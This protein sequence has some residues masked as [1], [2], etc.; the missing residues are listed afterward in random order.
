M[1]KILIYDDN[2]DDIKQLLHCINVYFDDIKI[3]YVTKIC[4]DSQMLFEIIK[5]Y[6][7]LFL[8]IQLNHENGIDIGLKL[9]HI[10]HDCRIIIISNYMKYALEGYKIHADRYFLKPI[11]QELFNIEME[12]IIK[13]HFNK[14]L[15]FYDP[16]IS[17]RKI[18]Y[19]EILY[20]EFYNR[21]TI[22][23]IS[24]GEKYSTYYP[25]KYWYK[26]LHE[27]GF[28]YSHQSFIV[29]LAQISAFGK[30]EVFLI[31]NDVIPLSRNSKHTLEVEYAKYLQGVL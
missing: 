22:I 1:L 10:Y 21:K 19:N 29:N 20:I 15:G 9:K 8:D 4:K 11:T 24:S 12:N 28:A 14:H 17:N 7:I 30:N 18:F 23:C 16:K 13:N 26:K 27:H 5:D 6:D 3:E 2:A 31:S 25:L